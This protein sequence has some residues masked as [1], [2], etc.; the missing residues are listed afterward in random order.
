[1]GAGSEIGGID[2][3]EGGKTKNCVDVPMYS[4]DSYADRF[5]RSK[6]PVNVLQIDV[7]G[8]DFNAMFGASSVLD[9]TLYLEFEHGGRGTWGALHLQDAVKLLDGKGFT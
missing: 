2:M 3:C 9:R 7:E 5:V 1:M 8:F 4:L 6:G